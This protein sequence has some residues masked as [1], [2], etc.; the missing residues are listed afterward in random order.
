[1]RVGFETGTNNTEETET[2]N[3]SRKAERD[4]GRLRAADKKMVNKELQKGETHAKLLVEE[5][6]KVK[7]DL[8][9]NFWHR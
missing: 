1:M 9:I 6:V 3:M 5:R 8:I 4:A 7:A 2:E